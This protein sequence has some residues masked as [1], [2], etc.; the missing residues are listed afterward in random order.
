MYGFF[1]QK[2]D[3]QSVT[4]P[5]KNEI[6]VPPFPHINV[7]LKK[8]PDRDDTRYLATFCGTATLTRGEGETGANKLKIWEWLNNFVTDCRPIAHRLR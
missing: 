8:V 2:L 3:L 1:F 5:E 6:F 7:V 4:K